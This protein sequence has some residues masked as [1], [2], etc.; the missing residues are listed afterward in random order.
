ML[1]LDASQALGEGRERVIYAHPKDPTRLVKVIK[2]RDSK[3][4]A[5]FTFGDIVKRHFPATRWRP[6]AKQM[7]EYTRLML[8]HKDDP[9]F[10]L[11]ISHL[12]G[13][14]PTNLGL[15][16]VTERVTAPDGSNA[17]T[18]EHLLDD[19]QL[20]DALLASLNTFV[21]GLYDLGVRAADLNAG[22]FVHG[23]RH[24][25]PNTAPQWLLVDGFGDSHAIPARSWSHWTNTIGLDDCFKRMSP[26]IPLHWNPK[27]RQFERP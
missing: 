22:N 15:G 8:S 19:G 18:L 17:P 9:E 10:I 27:S 21:T 26:H 7:A 11:P 24:I 3:S 4:Y 12:Y 13:F 14:E 1:M 25:G 20:T 23:Q 6:L 2:P 16:C 5:R